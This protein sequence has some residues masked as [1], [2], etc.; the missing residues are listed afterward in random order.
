MRLVK[1][2]LQARSGARPWRGTPWPRHLAGASGW[3]A[4]PSR[5]CRS[6]YALCDDYNVLWFIHSL[7]VTFLEPS[8]LG[9]STVGAFCVAQCEREYGYM[10]TLFIL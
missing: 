6:G 7:R 8:L 4:C 3:L 9:A 5:C 10:S 2:T 1:G